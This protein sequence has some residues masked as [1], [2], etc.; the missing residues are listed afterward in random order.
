MMDCVVVTGAGGIVGRSAVAR[1]SKSGWRVIPIV[2][3]TSFADVSGAV[4]ADLTRGWP[5]VGP[6]SHVVHLAA[7]LTHDPRYRDGDISGRLTRQIDDTVLAI[8]ERFGAR[9]IYASTCS[10]YDPADPREKAENSPVLRTDTPYRLAK[11]ETENRLLSDVRA[12]VFRLSAPYGPGMFASTVLPR[13][14]ETARSGGTIEVWGSGSREQN[15]VHTD[16]VADF[17]L[18][19]MRAENAGLYNVAGASIS[20]RELA[21]RVVRIV[22]AGRYAMSAA[23]DPMEGQTARYSVAAAT[24][25]LGWRPT[26]PLD[27]GIRKCRDLEFRH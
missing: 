7:A 6:F 13:F 25:D 18:R 1:L 12:M 17:I 4:A 23:R 22:Q 19:S 24:R 9:V 11:R 15:F 10:L 16:D 20:M 3:P 26:I 14:I 8:A 2:S 27:E 5:D 21:D